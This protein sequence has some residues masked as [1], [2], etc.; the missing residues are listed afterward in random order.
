MSKTYSA[1]ELEAPISMT[2]PSWEWSLRSGPEPPELLDAKTREVFQR[3]TLHFPGH[4]VSLNITLSVG[5][6]L[7]DDNTFAVTVAGRTLVYELPKPA[8]PVPTRKRVERDKKGQITAIV[9]E[10]VP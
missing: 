2:F 4:D 6:E 3:T 10:P 8:K 5:A 9:D 1:V 7:R